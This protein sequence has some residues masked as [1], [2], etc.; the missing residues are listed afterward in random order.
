MVSGFAFY[1]GRDNRQAKLQQRH[2]VKCCTISKPGDLVSG[3]AYIFVDNNYLISTGIVV[4]RID[5]V[6]MTASSS[7]SEQ[8]QLKA[9]DVPAIREGVYPPPQTPLSP[10]T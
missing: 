3:R 8:Y 2:N 9:H 7:D 6:T 4:W 5:I 10:R 1:H